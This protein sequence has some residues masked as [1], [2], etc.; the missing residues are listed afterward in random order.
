L[1]GMARR[2]F[3]LGRFVQVVLLPEDEVEEAA[4]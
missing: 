4:P 3:D 1:R 2:M